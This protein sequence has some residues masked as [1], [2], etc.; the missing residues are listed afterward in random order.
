[1]RDQAPDAGRSSSGGPA[2][3][4]GHARPRDAGRDTRLAAWLAVGWAA[5]LTGLAALWVR[6]PFLGS[7]TAFV[8]WSLPAAVAA[9][10]TWRWL[11]ARDIAEVPLTPGV[12]G[13]V[14]ALWSAAL[15]LAVSD[16]GAVLALDGLL[17]RRPWLER[18]GAAAR[19]APL[20]FGLGLSLAALS[21]AL[22]ARYRLARRPGVSDR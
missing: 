20:V 12:L 2:T 14:F 21:A 16:V 5:L 18:L 7:G 19:W 11:R 10:I 1:M 17:L 13:A 4:A 15:A 22:E 3:D 9:A 6:S 8:V